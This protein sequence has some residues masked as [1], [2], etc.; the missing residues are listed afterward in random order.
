NG[1]DYYANI[2][3]YRT[4]LGYVPQDDIV[5]KD[6]TVERALHYAAKLRLP[7]DF[8]SEQIQQRIN[9]VL[10]EVEMTARRK[11]PIKKL[12]GGQ[13]KRVS[14][15]LELL[16]NPGIFFLDE[17][18]SGLDAGL[19][20]KMMQLLRKLADR[21]HT[22]V[23][24]THTTANLHLCDAICFLAPGGRLA[25]FGPPDGAKAYFG[26]EDFAE[27]YAGL[28]PT[29]DNPQA[30]EEAEARFKRSP[31]YQDHIARPLGAAPS[32]GAAP[33]SAAT[34]ARKHTQ[35]R[36]PVA[37]FALLAQ[38]NL[39]LIRNNRSNLIIL[40]LQA[41]VIALVLMLLIRF[42][43]GAGLF[44]PDKVL[45][46]A[47]QITQTVVTTT[48]TT[49]NPTGA[50]R[51][52]LPSAGHSDPN[53]PVDCHQIAQLLSGDAASKADDTTL[54]NAREYAQRKGGVNAALQD[55]IIP[56]AGLNSLRA[57]F[58]VAY[59]AVMFGCVNG[60]RA[61]VKEASIYR[62]ERAVSLGILPYVF[63]KMGV[64]GLFALLQS[65]AVLVILQV[66][67]P[68]R[69][70]VILPVLP[71]VYATLALTALAGLAVGLAASAFAANEDV[72]N[73]LIPLLLIPQVV[74]A[75]A[76]IALKDWPV[77]L[78]A[79]ILPTR[80]ALTALGTTIGLHSD[81]LGGDAL[82]GNDSAFHGTL[83][84]TFSHADAVHRM[85]LAWGAL[86]ALILVLSILICV[87]LKRR[88]VRVRAGSART[89]AGRK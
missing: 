64:L 36:N 53:H 30:P 44:N 7:G 35:R 73:S 25:Y 10:E 80:W 54:R 43:I 78:V 57:I 23:L 11:Q 68:L 71:E 3:A 84:S 33:T 39:E 55:F 87:G 4:N 41:P 18:T 2:A 22:V 19:D 1:H 48:P 76:E 82:L 74:F 75:G 79:T 49:D 85:L 28:E 56:G 70:G 45:Q 83:L 29:E 34:T 40:L 21:G 5:H 15:A 42:E 46:C 6:L 24:V 69:G 51:L 62:R 47:P 50:L 86:G 81:K 61:L 72:A 66:F 31:A 16:A 67:E 59:I 14:I 88:D 26:A 12:S 13:R 65:A 63:S 89:K 9:E 58:M 17:P 77:Q 38:R 20:R 8:T 52:G 32:A 60:V 27:I 37:Q